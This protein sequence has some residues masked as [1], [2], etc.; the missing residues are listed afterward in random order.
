MEGLDPRSD[1][2]LIRQGHITVSLI[3]PRPLDET[4][5]RALLDEM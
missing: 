2:A 3:N 5:W 1:D 4:L